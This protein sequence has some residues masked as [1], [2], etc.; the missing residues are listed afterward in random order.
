VLEERELM[1]VGGDQS[2]RID[3]RV[4]A[5]TNADL[6]ALVAGGRFRQDL[7]YRLKVVTIRVPPLRERRPDTPH[8]VRGFLEE[9]SRANAV[10][11]KR[12]SDEALAALTEYAWPGNVRELKNLLESLLVSVTG[13]VIGLDD[14]PRHVRPAFDPSAPPHL[15]PGA[16]LADVERQIIQRTLERTGGN[17]TH[18]A[19]LLAIG[20]RTLQRK[21]RRYGLDVPPKRR[22]PRRAAAR[23]GSA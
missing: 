15:E 12:I 19:E 14:L 7:Y 1:R 22:R 18:A 9:L 10:E 16:T 20:V 2:L 17:R 13:D 23:D 6:E 3:V 21:I 8:L 11:P 4:I 5:A